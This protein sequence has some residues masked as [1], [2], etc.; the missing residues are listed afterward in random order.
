MLRTLNLTTGGADLDWNTTT[1]IQ[2]SILL[3]TIPGCYCET[4]SSQ[5]SKQTVPPI[6]TQ[7][8]LLA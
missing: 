7:H 6:V 8:K 5:I 3:T 2:I 4:F 1:V